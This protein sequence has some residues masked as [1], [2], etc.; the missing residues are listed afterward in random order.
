MASSN[1]AVLEVTEFFSTTHSTASVC[2]LRLNYRM[3]NF[4]HSTSNN[5]H[6][7][8]HVAADQTRT[9]GGTNY[10]PL[11]HTKLFQ[12]VDLK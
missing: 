6:E 1:S 10:R 11:V 5:L 8:F 3:L 7:T 9:M 12:F 2:L 4:M